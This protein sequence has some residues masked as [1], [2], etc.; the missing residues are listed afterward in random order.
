MR[1]VLFVLLFLSLTYKAFAIPTSNIPAVGYKAPCYLGQLNVENVEYVTLNSTKLPINAVSDNELFQVQNGKLI[2]LTC[3]KE[4]YVFTQNANQSTGH[5]NT[6]DM[7]CD[8]GTF[9]KQ[10]ETDFCDAK[11]N[12]SPLIAVG[13]SIAGSYT[14]SDYNLFP[15]QMVYL[16]CPAGKTTRY[17][18]NTNVTCQSNGLLDS[19]SPG[20]FASSNS[21]KHNN[22][23]FPEGSSLVCNQSKFGLVTVT[24]NKRKMA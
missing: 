12:I 2:I 4:N 7:Y 18:N 5:R 1:S 13:Y 21:C 15:G 20:C 19:I 11:C 6:F 9:K 8:N 23:N 16:T 10:N 22:L 17:G 3:K 24:C 14:N